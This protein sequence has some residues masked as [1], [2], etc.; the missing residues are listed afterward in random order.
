M[1]QTT[2]DVV[3]LQ[4]EAIHRVLPDLYGYPDHL[5]SKIQAKPAQKVSSREYRIPLGI[6]PGSRF[7]Y[8]SLAG[9][10][11]GRG[12]A[13]VYDKAVLTPLASRIAVEINEDALKQT[14]GEPKSIRN[15]LNVEVKKAM[16]E[17]RTQH[18]ASLQTAGD[19]VLATV[20]AAGGGVITVAAAPFYAQLLR[21]RQKV[22][23]YDSTKATNRGTAEIT[24][25]NYKTSACTVDTVP[26]G[27]VATDVLLPEGVSGANPVWYY[28]KAYHISDAAAGTWLGFNRANEPAI[29]ANGVNASNNALTT[30]PVRLALNMILQRMDTVNPK[31]LRAHMHPC[32]L[33]AW[34]ELAVLV[35]EIHKGSGN[36]NVDLL[37]D[38]KFMAGVQIERDTQAARDRI[39][40]ID[41]D[42]W[43]KIES[44]PVDFLKTPDGRYFTRPFDTTGGSPLAALLFHIIWFG[45]FFTD[46]PAAQ[47]YIYSLAIPSGYTTI[48]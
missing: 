28:G 1:P 39:D 29:R 19:G 21:R 33:A 48:G 22:C 41:F 10:A 13:S 45:Q 14:E 25:I 40:F 44:A 3:A 16:K 27:T 11:L 9:G 37:F 43:G 35:S 7:G 47:A 12:T 42:A 18:N 2:A 20:T 4:M 8:V 38:Q 31:S 6:G 30:A 46:N 17:M 34:E 32:Q 23:V 15:L 5:A 36:E 24:A 26:G